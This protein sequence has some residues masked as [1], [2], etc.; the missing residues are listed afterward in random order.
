VLPIQFCDYA[1]KAID[2]VLAY[3]A[4]CLPQLFYNVKNLVFGKKAMCRKTQLQKTP[5]V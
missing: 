4:S 3:S 2:R 1:P 5:K